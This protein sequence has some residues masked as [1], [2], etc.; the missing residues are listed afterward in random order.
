MVVQKTQE[1]KLNVEAM[2]VH[3]CVHTR[4]AGASRPLLDLHCSHNLAA[5][6]SRLCLGGETKHLSR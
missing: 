4:I 3:E 6:I 1:V 2:A 5:Q